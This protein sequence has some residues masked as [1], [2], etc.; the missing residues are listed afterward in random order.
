MTDGVRPA[1]SLVVR[2]YVKNWSPFVNGHRKPDREPVCKTRNGSGHARQS[3]LSEIMLYIGIDISKNTFH[4]S[5]MFTPQNFS[6]I[7][8][9]FNNDIPG[10]KDFCVM[11]MALHPIVCME[12]TGV[13][14]E[15]LC[16]FL[17]RSGYTIYV[18]PPQYVRRAFRLK[19]KTDRVDSVMIAEYAYRFRDQL[20]LWQPQD[21]LIEQIRTLLNNRDIFQKEKTAHK[22]MLRALEKKEFQDLDHYHQETIDYFSKTTK[23][24]D[25]KLKFLIKNANP[26]IQTGFEILLSIP[27][28]GWQWA[29]NF[30]VIS[31]GF[32]QLNYRH[33]CAYLGL[34]PYEYQSGLS[35]Y[36]HPKT[37]RSGSDIFRKLLYLSAI[38]V[39]RQGQFQRKYF[40]QKKAEGKN[41]KLILNNIQNKLLKIACACV[42]DQ[43]PYHEGHRSL[44]PLK[45][46]RISE[47]YKFS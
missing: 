22:N 24:L 14:G 7:G 25:E 11:F 13:Y 27:G 9:E 23:S 33:L 35:V 26:E 21:K 3:L 16:Y 19:R 8:K 1:V 31:K 4:A 42:R 17:Y 6:F 5:G 20:H 41:G 40:Q 47:K 45:D 32:S 10:C 46:N 15:K 34:V 36:K 2:D 38:S 43:K 18:E 44:N 30:F 29:A 39:C 12:A 28:V 37:D